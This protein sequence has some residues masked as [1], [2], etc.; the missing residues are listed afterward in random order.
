MSDPTQV[1]SCFDSRP[2]ECVKQFDRVEERLEKIIK[3]LI[4][5]SNPSRGITVRLDRL[6]QS[7]LGH[8]WALRAIGTAVITVFAGIVIAAVIHFSNG[9]NAP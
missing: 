4:G 9:G 3:L 1:K 8:K 6:E 2:P 5:N 7:A